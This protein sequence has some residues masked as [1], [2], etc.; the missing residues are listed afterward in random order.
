MPGHEKGVISNNRLWYKVN[1]EWMHVSKT[2]QT[3]K[4]NTLFHMC[5]F[6]N[7]LHRPVVCFIVVIIVLSK[8]SFFF[9]YEE[10]FLWYIANDKISPI[11]MHYHYFF[12]FFMFEVPTKCSEEIYYWACFSVKMCMTITGMIN[13]CHFN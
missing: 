4:C 11:L 13:Q 8:C 9:Y 1:L 3:H 7:S 10:N 5:Y 12:E 6:N 2:N